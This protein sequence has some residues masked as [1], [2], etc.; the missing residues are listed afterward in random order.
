MKR[1]IRQQHLIPAVMVLI[2]VLKHASRRNAIT[3]VVHRKEGGEF[4]PWNK[5]YGI[6]FAEAQIREDDTLLT[7]AVREPRIFAMDESR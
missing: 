2:A 4:R 3:A 1:L 5:N 7:K 6:L